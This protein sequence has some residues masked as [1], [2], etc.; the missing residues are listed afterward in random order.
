MSGT[1]GGDVWESKADSDE[2]RGDR[3]EE[4]RRLQHELRLLSIE[5]HLLGFM[6]EPTSTACSSTLWPNG[7][8]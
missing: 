7:V 4:Y 6:T 5:E 1:L 8:L 2:F 3:T